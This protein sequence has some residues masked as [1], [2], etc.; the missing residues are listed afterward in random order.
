[1]RPQC[2]PFA[3]MAPHLPLNDD[4]PP[5]PP[6]LPSLH[7]PPTLT[8]QVSKPSVL[9]PLRSSATSADG[10]EARTAPSAS[11]TSRPHD[12]GA[13]NA[14]RGASN[15][16]HFVVASACGP[17]VALEVKSMLVIPKSVNARPRA[18]KHVLRE[19][20]LVTLE[21]VHRAD[22]L[23]VGPLCVFPQL[24]GGGGTHSLLGKAL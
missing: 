20:V 11:P 22:Q 21:R 19:K 8:S 13:K 6:Y 9:R 4:T 2:S 12:D 24:V 14:G 18:L 15:Q 5:S 7:P 16:P 3:F 17:S 10:L 1:M 23:L